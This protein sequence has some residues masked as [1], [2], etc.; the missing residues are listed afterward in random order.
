MDELLDISTN[1]VTGWEGPWKKGTRVTYEGEPVFELHEL[2]QGD[3]FNFVS[4]EHGKW[5]RSDRRN[6]LIEQKVDED[7]FAEYINLHMDE[8]S[9]TGGR[10]LVCKCEVTP[11]E[12]ASYLPYLI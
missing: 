7:H 1:L 5:L 12:R 6:L 3:I 2:S 4:R 10:A 9:T 8:L 11:E